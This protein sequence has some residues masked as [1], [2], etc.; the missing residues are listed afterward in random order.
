M[1][2]NLKNKVKKPTRHP[3]YFEVVVEDIKGKLEV[4]I[5][6]QTVASERFDKFE[7]QTNSSFQTVFSYLSR[8]D[9]ELKLI[10]R[11]IEDLR[12]TLTTKADLERLEILERR[13]QKIEEVLVKSRKN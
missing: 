9:D 1:K 6:G 7:Q 13:V 12:K 10:R 8:I 3:D 5:E 11:E 2:N 4:I